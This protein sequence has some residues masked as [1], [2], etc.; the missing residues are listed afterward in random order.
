MEIPLIADSAGLPYIPHFP[1]STTLTLLRQY[2]TR[3]HLALTTIEDEQLFPNGSIA[4]PD[5][6]FA[7]LEHQTDSILAV[8]ADYPPERVIIGNNWLPM[9]NYPDHYGRMLNRLRKSHT[10]FFSYSAQLNRLDKV[11]LWAASD[12][13][14]IDYTPSALANHKEYARTH[15]ASAGKIAQAHQKSIFIF[16]ANILGTDPVLQLKN[17]LRFWPEDRSITGICINTI[18]SR[19]AARDSSSYYGLRKSANF[20]QYL[21]KYRRPPE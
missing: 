5:A 8:I 1:L 13:I 12:E 17:R 16:R 14:S 4:D 18:Y 7:A 20:F 15:N 6:W 11:P 3:L 2:K 9:E 21:D 19:I 10:N